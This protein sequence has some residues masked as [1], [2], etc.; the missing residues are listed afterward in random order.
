[1]GAWTRWDNRWRLDMTPA[2]C[3]PDHV[4]PA[5]RSRYYTG[6]GHPYHLGR[7]PVPVFIAIT[8]LMRYAARWEPGGWPVQGYGAPWAGDSGAFAALMLARDSDGHPWSMPYTS[9]ASTWVDLVE[10]IS[11]GC[12]RELGPDF[13]A[14]QDWP[15]EPNVLA[16]TEKTVREH[17]KLTLDS[18][19][20]LTGENEWMPWLRTLQ[21]WHLEEY[22]E[23]Y[24]MYRD[25]GVDMDGQLVGI[26]SVCRRGSQKGIETIVRGLAPL[27]MRMH[28][29]GLSINGLRLIGHLLAS[30][31]SQ[32]WSKTAREEHIL[33]PGCDHRSRATGEP[34][35]CRNCFRYAL[36]YREEV[37]DAIR[38]SWATPEPAPEPQHVQLDLFG[39]AA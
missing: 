31:D 36:A 1:M 37:L 2:D 24:Q 25:A 34:T 39:A 16:R 32:A 27:G 33:L 22:Q 10:K 30:S 8:T 7:S 18:Y 9:Y 13:I 38:T 17:Q 29:F 5:R 28:G 19:M 26:G 6:I 20:M 15:C 35:D 3:R 4:D 23:H 14:I 11:H 21:G 12:F